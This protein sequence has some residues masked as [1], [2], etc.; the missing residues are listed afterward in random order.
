MRF[1][2]VLSVLLVSISAGAHAEP[3]QPKADK[4]VR[5]GIVDQSGSVLGL[6]F[7]PPDENG[8]DITKSGIN[9]TLKKD[10]ESAEENREIEAY[11]VNLDAPVSPI[12]GYIERIKKNTHEG[13]SKN[14]RFKIK[15]FDVTEDSKNSLCA[16][17]YLLLEDTQPTRTGNNQQKKWSEQHVL[18]CGSLKYKRI[19][20]EVRYYHRY[21]ESNRDSQFID[22]A[23][24]VLESVVIEDK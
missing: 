5:I 10:G 20:F 17:V 11:L 21:Y 23:N 16:R 15:A 6:H 13:Y 14:E 3:Y 2:V 22:E 8:W 1:L 12:S 24:K 19:G 7:M 18:S 9:V 4:P